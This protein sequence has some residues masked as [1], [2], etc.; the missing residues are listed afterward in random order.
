MQKALCVG[1]AV[2]LASAKLVT[3][4]VM[5]MDGAEVHKCQ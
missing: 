3:K 4:D 1:L 5:Y 2:G